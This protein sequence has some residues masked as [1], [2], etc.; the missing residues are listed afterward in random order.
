MKAVVTRGN[1][2]YDTLDY[3]DVPVPQPGPGEVL[4]QVL[5]AGF[6]NPVINTR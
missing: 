6:N 2:G 5:A 1:G 4:L 3:C